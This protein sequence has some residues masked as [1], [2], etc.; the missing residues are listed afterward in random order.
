MTL[1]EINEFV[2][3]GLVGHLGIVYTY[4]SQERIEAI[5]DVDSRT[6]QPAGILHGGASLAL[7]ESVAGMG[8]RIVSPDRVVV[9]T[10]I[11]GNHI[12]SAFRG[13]SVKGVGTIIHRGRSTHIWNVDIIN[14]NGKL[15]SSIR[16]LNTILEKR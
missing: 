8:S 2:S 13:E 12:S 14:S 9:G 3:D 11:S 5:M 10:Q 1:E 6:C 15:I 16:V 7:A 4:A